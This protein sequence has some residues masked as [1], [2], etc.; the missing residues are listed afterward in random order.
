MFIISKGL[1]FIVLALKN[2]VTDSPTKVQ[3][4]GK[5]IAPYYL[6]LN[7]LTEK[8]SNYPSFFFDW[9]DKLE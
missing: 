2:V 9:V 3:K 8:T 4:P 7:L 6:N 1:S 5:L